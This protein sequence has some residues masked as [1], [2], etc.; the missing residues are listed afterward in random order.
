[1][2]TPHRPPFQ[3]LSPPQR[4]AWIEEMVAEK[5]DR[6]SVTELGDYVFHDLLTFYSKQATDQDLELL[7]DELYC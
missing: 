7:W 3:H 4:Q 6:Y 1:M 2:S 5:V